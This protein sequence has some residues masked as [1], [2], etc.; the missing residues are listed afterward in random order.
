VTAAS[1]VVPLP[2]PPAAEAL[3][4]VAE[5][6]EPFTDVDRRWRLDLVGPVE[7]HAVGSRR[8]DWSWVGVDATVRE[9]RALRRPRPVEVTL[10]PWSADAVDLVL[11]PRRGRADDAFHAAAA[12]LLRTVAGALLLGADGAAHD[13]LHLVRSG[14]TPGTARPSERLV[15][16]GPR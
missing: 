1:W 7:V 9:L 12:A 11:R 2:L 4:A 13:R 8:G 6:G 3:L 5:V 15:V 14:R 10:Q 16:A